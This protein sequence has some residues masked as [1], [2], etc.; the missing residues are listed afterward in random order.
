MCA[1]SPSKKQ[2]RSRNRA[3]RAVAT[4]DPIG[5]DLQHRTVCLFERCPDVLGGL[6][7]VNQLSVPLHVH[8]PVAQGFSEQPLVL[9]LTQDQQKRIRTQILPDVTERDAC[10]PL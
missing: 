10:S 8:S 9:V 6:Y 1:A 7:Q 5:L 2:R 4:G 3:A